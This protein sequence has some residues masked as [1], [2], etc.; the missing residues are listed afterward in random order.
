[1][2][3]FLNEK[4]ILYINNKIKMQKNIFFSLSKSVLKG[5]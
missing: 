2:N 3:I 1:M 4:N 5:L